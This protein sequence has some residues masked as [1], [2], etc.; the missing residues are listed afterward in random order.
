MISWRD[1]DA[2]PAYNTASVLLVISH[3]FATI[4][5]TK[6]LNI[7]NEILSFNEESNEDDRFS[8]TS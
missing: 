3:H 7:D 6:K 4:V 8:V 2:A 1:V 5:L